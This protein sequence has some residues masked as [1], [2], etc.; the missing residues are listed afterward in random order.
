MTPASRGRAV[1]I[2]NSVG[3]IAH[4]LMG[5]SS[6]TITPPRERERVLNV[7]PPHAEAMPVD[8]DEFRGEGFPWLVNVDPSSRPSLVKIAHFDKA[9]PAGGSTMRR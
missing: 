4:L 9:A 8:A 5:L 3:F 1:T 7:E 2:A 6:G